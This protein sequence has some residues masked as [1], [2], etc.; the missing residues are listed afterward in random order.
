MKLFQICVK[1]QNKTKPQK[2]DP[3]TTTKP[4]QPLAQPPRSN[5]S[6]RGSCGPDGSHAAGGKADRAAAVQN[7]S[8]NAERRVP[9]TPGEGSAPTC[10]PKGIESVCTHRQHIRARSLL[11]TAKSD[12]DPDAPQLSEKTRRV[13]PTEQ[14]SAIK[15]K[16]LGHLLRLG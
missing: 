3:T 16:T 10:L 9:A 8:S 12:R 4:A 14:D 13:R 5:R 1:K 6:R 2:P 15:R 11:T 7:S